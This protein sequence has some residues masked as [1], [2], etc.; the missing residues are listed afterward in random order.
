MF[1]LVALPP[2]G[3][4]NRDIPTGL[5]AVVFALMFDEAWRAE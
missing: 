4:Y 3:G 5:N 2:D 1:I